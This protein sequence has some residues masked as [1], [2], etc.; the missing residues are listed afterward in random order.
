MEAA[1]KSVGIFLLAYFSYYYILRFIQS[2][3]QGLLGSINSNLAKFIYAL[4]TPAHELAH[5]LVAILCGA[6]IEQV[7]LFPKGNRPGFVKSRIGSSIPFLISIKEFLIAIAPVLVN[8]PLFIFIESTFILK[9]KVSEMSKIAD[10]RI[11]LSKEGLITIVLFLIL[12]SGIAPSHEDF[13]GMVKGLI[14]LSFVIFGMT[15]LTSLISDMKWVNI[16]PVLTIL[17][18]YFEIILAVLIINA[19][20]NFRNCFRMTGMILMNALRH[21]FK[22]N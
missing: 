12:I 7:Q 14:I 16:N 2:V 5:L 22:R 9:C 11:M 17:L 3:F 4:G 8:I 10:P 13:K 20:L 15:Y 19:I 18:Y 6:R 21:T 1:I